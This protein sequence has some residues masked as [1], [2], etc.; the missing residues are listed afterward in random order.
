MS[1]GGLERLKEV[2][3]VFGLLVTGLGTS[4]TGFFPG[5]IVGCWK[6]ERGL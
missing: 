1:T 6:W 5:V 2:G 3:V 4:L